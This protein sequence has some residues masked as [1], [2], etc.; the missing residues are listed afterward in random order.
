MSTVAD[1]IDADMSNILNY[2]NST[3]YANNVSKIASKLEE[4]ALSS[5]KNNTT[6]PA[7]RKIS[8]PINLEV[9]RE[10]DFYLTLKTFDGKAEF[11]RVLSGDLAA[12]LT[13]FGYETSVQTRLPEGTN[14]VP[15]YTTLIIE[16]PSGGEENE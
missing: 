7:I 4:Y 16:I 8:I 11:I 1:L 14:N 9:E 5:I 13:N 6:T 2:L 15:Y 3:S 10:V 12:T